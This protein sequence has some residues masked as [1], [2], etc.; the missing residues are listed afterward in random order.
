MR[1]KF[2][3][4]A[5]AGLLSISGLVPGYPASNAMAQ[6]KPLKIGVLN[7]MTIMSA[8]AGPGSVLAAQL[9]IEDSAAVTKGW[10]VELV[11]ADHLMKPDIASAIA[12]AWF[13]VDK[14]DA[15]FDLP[16]SST[17][18]AGV[19]IGKTH[20]K[21]IIISGGG[22]ADLTGKACAP[23]TVHWTYDSYAVTNAMAKAIIKDGGNSWYFITADYAF[24]HALENDATAVLKASGASVLGSVRH[25]FNTNDFSSF[26]LKA[27]GSGAKV[28]GLATSGTDIMTLIKQARE[29]GINDKGQRLAALLL[30][31]TDVKALGLEQTQGLALS[32]TYYWDINDRTRSFGRRFM[33][34]HGGMPN[35][36]HAG[37]YGS[38]IH[39]LKA[40]SALG[41]AADGKKVVDQMK[42]MPTD[43]DA[44]G[45]GMI[46]A[47]GRKI[48]PVYLFEV[49]KPSESKE[50]WDLFKLRATVPGE[51]A[52][53]PMNPAECTMLKG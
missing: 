22:S 46:R 34:R 8:N 42:A 33:A 41:S 12:R 47:D 38:V 39:Y 27:Q 16:V 23:T 20:N 43:D 13:D 7:N 19:E 25:P 18:F 31:V 40:V 52:F 17:T 10:K 36:V 21:P 1:R 4:M 51:E 5:A 29:F 53:R 24:G 26:I 14:V 32:E 11:N 50:P 15:I 49:K 35:M 37:V 44:F 2:A 9:A 6:D 3:V 30:G 28:I 48:H 45:K